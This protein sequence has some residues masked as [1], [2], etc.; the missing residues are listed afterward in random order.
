MVRWACLAERFD[1]PLRRASAA[2]G[3]PAAEAVAGPTLTG[4]V[5]GGAEVLAFA[6]ERRKFRA[7]DDGEVGTGSGVS[8]TNEAAET[9]GVAGSDEAADAGSERSVPNAVLPAGHPVPLSAGAGSCSAGAG[10]TAGEAGSTGGEATDDDVPW[11]SSVQPSST[12]GAAG[13]ATDR[14]KLDESRGV[15]MVSA[16]S[17]GTSWATASFL[18]AAEPPL[19]KTSLAA[20]GGPCDLRPGGPHGRRRYDLGVLVGVRR[21]VIVVVMLYG[22]DRGRGSTRAVRRIRAPVQAVLL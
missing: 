11:S 13:A 1:D 6:L 15:R 19:A 20:G 17:A 5:R 8:H 2:G 12:S 3:A 22:H 21:Q 16:G 4:G 18:S 7:G 9:V 10:S 14:L